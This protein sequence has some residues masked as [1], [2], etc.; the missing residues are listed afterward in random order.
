[1]HEFP[2]D[3]ARLAELI[4]YV[5]ARCADWDGFDPVLLDR[6][7]F[8][9]DFLHYRR[10]GAPITGQAYRRGPAGPTPRGLSRVLRALAKEFAVV[11]TP[12]GDGLHVRRRPAAL[13]AARLSAFAESDLATVEEVL[14]HY[15]GVRQA[16]VR[17]SPGQP[18]GRWPG[19][20]ERSECG[21]G[22]DWLGAGPD[23]PDYLEIPWREAGPRA[24]LPYSLAITAPEHWTRG[25]RVL[26]L[27]APSGAFRPAAFPAP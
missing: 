16:E 27:P 19:E 3:D 12:E 5:S 14:G 7:L 13:R 24:I 1:M 18:G 2:A 20:R 26:N 4:L 9:A 17:Q 6:I 25:P 22:A 10:F 15:R 8:Q 11:E 23:E 21:Q